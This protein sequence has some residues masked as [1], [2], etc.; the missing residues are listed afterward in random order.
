MRAPVHIGILLAAVLP[1]AAAFAQEPPA[2]PAAPPLPVRHA[3]ARRSADS[4]AGACTPRKK[5]GASTAATSVSE[6]MLEAIASVGGAK[7][8]AARRK[9]GRKVLV[10]ASRPVKW[11]K[12]KA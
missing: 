8:L 9:K 6:A 4:E 7:V 12:M 2:S 3:T 10:P 1:V 11:N 5:R